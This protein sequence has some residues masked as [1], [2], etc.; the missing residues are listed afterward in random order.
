MSARRLGLHASVATLAALAGVGVHAAPNVA[1]ENILVS[2]RNGLTNIQIW[3]ACRMR[4]MEHTP[5]KAGLELRIRVLADGECA[6]LLEQ[7]SAEVYLPSGRRLGS[8]AD[9]RFEDSGGGESY[10]TLRFDAPQQFSV[11]QHAVGW[12]EIY[13]DTTVDS[14]TLPA[15]VPP[16]IEVAPPS[17]APVPAA[18]PAI[19]PARETPARP[20]QRQVVSEDGEYVVQ[21]GVFADV[22]R[23]AAALT[24]VGGDLH[25]YT[26]EFELNGK[27]WH[28]LQVGFFA[29]EQDAETSLGTL[30]AT[31]PD[32]WV[33][34]VSADEARDARSS[35]ALAA[36]DARSLEA[37]RIVEGSTADSAELSAWMR[38]ART[39]LIERRYA[40]AIDSYTLVLQRPAHEHRATARE[41][42][43]VALERSGQTQRAIA[44]Y[45]A[46]L[47]DPP[48]D[49][50][51]RRVRERLDTLRTASIVPPAAPARAAAASSG[52]W[53]IYGGVSQYYWRNEQELVHDGNRLLASSGVLALADVTAARSGER[54]DVLARLN[55]AYQLNL[56]DFDDRGDIFWMSDAYL[57]VADKE[58]GLEAR[59]GR[60]TRR[61]DGVLGRF[62]GVGLR[63][64]WRPDITLSVSGGLPVDAPRFRPEPERYFYAASAQIE[65]L[66]ERVSINAY[67]QHQIADGIDDRRA[68]GGEVRY[69]DGGVSVIGLVDYDMTYAELNTALLNG[70]WVTDNDW[71]FSGSVRFGMLPFLTTRNALAG[72]TVST[73]DELLDTYSE[74]QIRTLARHRTA[75]A[76]SLSA[77][78]RLP[79]SERYDL[80]FDVTT[81]QADATTASAGVASIPDTGTQVFYSA[82]LIGSSVLR[83]GDLGVLT[84]RHDTT[85][86][87]DASTLLLDL[88]L[89]LSEGLRVSPRLALT[90][91][92]DNVNGTDQLIA[93]P[94]VRVIYRW[95]ALMVELEGGGRW[96]SR[97]LPPTE[98]D[99]FTP[100]G[101]EELLGGYINVGYR[102]EF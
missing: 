101:T 6:E 21:L 33:R 75:Q 55:G 26:T 53:Q 66:W 97:D 54:F 87:R 16:P 10:I 44:E 60:Q 102:L 22:S 28:G 40:D 46:Y 39:A 37:V 89:P 14:A 25:A 17:S 19:A 42:L 62:D 20:S 81:R 57:D 24:R 79:L 30:R 91:R 96:S 23:A 7:V 36:R 67:T 80:S 15:A 27:T 59:A 78:I 86:T 92:Q 83:D 11:R 71:R 69:R 4:Y 64:R 88:R 76:S 41:N 84:L 47:V 85:R 8:V 77:G 58:L 70:V 98:L 18:P 3:P 51:A 5:G 45:E 13:V 90:S 65:D 38:S 32:S 48:T 1:L 34:L 50:D 73:V 99:P 43:G 49:A 68:V 29:S 9:V 31:F 94:S 2:K 12:I 95:R 100:D 52:G 72:Q 63:Y 74:G 93:A 35:S 61:S 82:S 56:V